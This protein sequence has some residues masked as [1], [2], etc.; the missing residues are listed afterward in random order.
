MVKTDSPG[1][2]LTASDC[3]TDEVPVVAFGTK[4]RSVIS[5]SENESMLTNAQLTI[6]ITY[7]Y[8]LCCMRM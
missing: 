2:K 4:T 8:T 1:L 5:A 6:I 7:N 3:K